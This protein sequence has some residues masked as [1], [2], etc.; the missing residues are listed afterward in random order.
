MW[1]KVE[2]FVDR[3]TQWWGSYQFQGS[4]RYVLAN[5]LKPLKVDLKKWNVE[6]FGN[7]AVKKTQFWIGLAE[8]DNVAEGRPLTVDEKLEMER[9]VGELEKM[10]L[11]EEIS[12]RQKSQALRFKEG[13]KNT[14]F[15]HRLANSNI[16]YLLC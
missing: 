5:K 12:W 4:P 9:T 10:I 16:R 7:V 2:G 11:L 3:V 15:F 6:S 14:K 1:L 8:L 13:D